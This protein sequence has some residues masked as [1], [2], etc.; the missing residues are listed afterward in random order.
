MYGCQQWVYRLAGGFLKPVLK[1]KIKQKKY[2]NTIIWCHATGA[3]P[4]M[5]NY[6]RGLEHSKNAQIDSSTPAKKI[7]ISVLRF[8]SRF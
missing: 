5:V 4:E 7:V 6:R 3:V 1:Q 8:R 2:A